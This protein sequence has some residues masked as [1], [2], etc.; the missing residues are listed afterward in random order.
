MDL[1]ARTVSRDGRE[2]ELQHQEF[3]LLE[4]LLRNAGR[5]VTRTMLLEKVWDLNFDPGDQCRGVPYEPLAV[6]GRP[7]L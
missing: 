3:K 6:E 7:R 2:I 1:L 5:V 4:Y